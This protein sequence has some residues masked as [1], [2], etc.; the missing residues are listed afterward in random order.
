MY[1][2]VRIKKHLHTVNRR[3]KRREIPDSEEDNEAAEPEEDHGKDH[4][5]EDEGED[6]EQEED[7]SHAGSGDDE[8]TQ[9]SKNE[10]TTKKPELKKPALKKVPATKA[11]R[12]KTPTFKATSSKNAS[13][14]LPKE[15]DGT[16]DGK[17]ANNGSWSERS[18]ADESEDEDGADLTAAATAAAFDGDEQLSS[19]DDDKVKQ[20]Q[21]AHEHEQRDLNEQASDP[22]SDTDH[23][24]QKRKRAV[25]SLE[26]AR[27][28][29]RRSRDARLGVPELYTARPI[30]NIGLSNSRNEKRV[31]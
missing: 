23:G 3:T 28:S 2:V 26:R 12:T 7:Q 6:D 13:F 8:D 17:E 21:E 29:R 11:A 25:L 18:E 15:R 5:D 1:R 22:L 4:D 24:S 9:V 16:S 14:D 19:L 27:G 31:V 20:L 10:Q 30:Q